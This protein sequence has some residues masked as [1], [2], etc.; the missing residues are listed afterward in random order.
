M[1]D[2][3]HTIQSRETLIERVCA[4]EAENKLFKESEL[5]FKNFFENSLEGFGII[6]GDRFVQV[7]RSFYENLGFDSPDFLYTHSIFDYLTFESR[8]Y[9]EKQYKNL[10]SGELYDKQFE[11]GV[12]DRNGEIHTIEV[13]LNDLQIGSD[14]YLMGSFLDVTKRKKAEQLLRESEEKY[15]NAVERASDAIIILQNGKFVYANPRALMLSGYSSEEFMNM[16]F[17]RYFHPDHIGKMREYYERREEFYERVARGEL[18]LSFFET[19]FLRKDG[20]AVF[21][22]ISVSLITYRGLPADLIIIR[23]I[24]DRKRIEEEKARLESQ[25]LLKKIQ[26]AKLQKELEIARGIQKALLPTEFPQVPGYDFSAINIPS[27]TIGGDLYYF[28]E[29]P[30][31]ELGISIGDISGKG[32]PGAVLM[33]N[34]CATFCGLVRQSRRSN[35]VI[36]KLNDALYHHTQANQFTTFFYG[37]LN[38]RLHTFRYTNAGHNPPILYRQN[39]TYK[40]LKTGGTILGFLPNIMYRRSN[41]SLQ[42][43]DVLFLYTDGIS[44][45]L[46]RRSKEFGVEGIMT[47]LKKNKRLPAKKILES[48]LATVLKYTKKVSQEDDLTAVV[49]KKE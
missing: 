3:A 45:S 20:S 12:Y 9:I 25:L 18:K 15:R 37:I 19:A 34:V 38:P 13:K 24:T 8:I 6:K 46:D 10:V 4:L 36:K 5:K 16:P 49:I 29:L 43:G 1:I 28:I 47:C 41:I 35:I 17:L 30:N 14:I 48:M 42:P 32:I 39:D 40:E 26:E 33:A 31:D 7:N 44:E 27:Q 22:E 2:N 21:A 11:I 23:D